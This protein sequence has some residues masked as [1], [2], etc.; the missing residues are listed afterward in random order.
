MMSCT[1]QLGP[2]VWGVGK[3]LLLAGALLATYLVF[4]AIA[5]RVAV[6]ARE[7]T[8]PDLVGRQLEDASALAAEQGLTLRIDQTRRPDNKVAAGH[9]LQQDPPG[10]AT[11]R[12]QRAIRVW[13]SAGP[14]AIVAPR[15]IGESERAAQIRLTQDGVATASVAEIRDADYP[16]GVVIAQDPPPETHTSEVHLLVNRGE[17]R[18]TY[19]MPDLI[20]VDGERAADLLRARGFRV[21]IVSQ[22][23]SP[24]I[25]PGVVIRQTPA[26]GYQVHPGDAISIEV[27]R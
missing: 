26:G 15:L 27:S 13:V 25:P 11:A 20:G 3:L 17:D 23:S 24:G 6:R 2:R 22:Q 1:M 10:G 14:R 12:R 5:M 7:I 16:P 21:A 4:A 9:V 19:I 8:V 18:I